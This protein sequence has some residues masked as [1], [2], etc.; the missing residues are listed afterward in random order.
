M[1]GGGR[2][3]RDGGGGICI[4]RVDSLCCKAESNATFKSNCTPI[5]KDKI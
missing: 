3:D 2:E 5:K 1:G 4:H